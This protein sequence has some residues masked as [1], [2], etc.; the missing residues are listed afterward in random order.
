[1]SVTVN[2]ARLFRLLTSGTIPIF[3][4]LLLY[5]GCVCHHKPER[6]SVS[7]GR[8]PPSSDFLSQSDADYEF[9]EKVQS[10]AYDI[11]G[12][13]PPFGKNWESVVTEDELLN[14]VADL[15]NQSQEQ[16]IRAREQLRALLRKMP[17]GR[18]STRMEN[19]FSYFIAA[20]IRTHVVAAVKSLGYSDPH[21]ILGTLPTY[22]ANARNIPA[23]SGR[24]IVV[25]NIELF[26]AINRFCKALE[27]VVSIETGGGKVALS[28]SARR[29]AELAKPQSDVFIHFLDVGL[30]YLRVSRGED[31]LLPDDYMRLQSSLITAMEI[32]VLGHEY[33]HALLNHRTITGDAKSLGLALAGAAAQLP[34]SDAL[35]SWIQ[36][37]EADRLGVKIMKKSLELDDSAI[38]E[39]MMAGPD[40]ALQ[41]LDYL[42]LAKS[43]YQ[44]GVDASIADASGCPEEKLY[45]AAI[46]CIEQQRT[47]S[48]EVP[49]DLPGNSHFSDHP[50]GSLRRL[51]I[52]SYMKTTQLIE[53]QKQYL[54]IGGAFADLIHLMWP[55]TLKVYAEVRKQKPP[56]QSAPPEQ[57]P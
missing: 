38:P 47:E 55:N 50:P 35:K 40:L 29:T 49:T 44:D 16:K 8:T 10:N 42:D 41:L 21:I 30:E 25:L 27:P 18:L 15:G 2:E 7:L 43:L 5:V 32:F 57:G 37:L 48:C 45:T 52:R 24:R 26:N 31:Y 39:V 54:D 11:P 51:G 13:F 3:F 17:E 1:M 12:S 53:P 34:P 22:S 23:P 14:R 33:S 4:T 56:A 36:E 28:V 6:E 19:P 20:N 9:L 46:R